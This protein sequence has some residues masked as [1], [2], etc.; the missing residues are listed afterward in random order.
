M[1]L[2]Y[3]SIL[4]LSLHTLSS[5]TDNETQ[6][7]SSPSQNNDES[8][9]EEDSFQL[10]DLNIN[11][12]VLIEPENTKP[13]VNMD[14]IENNE[15]LLESKN[16]NSLMSLMS[17]SYPL[18]SKNGFNVFDDDQQYL[19]RLRKHLPSNQKDKYR[20]LSYDEFVN[21]IKT[22]SLEARISSLSQENVILKKEISRLIHKENASPGLMEIL[23]Y[24]KEENPLVINRFSKMSMDSILEDIK[25][26]YIEPYDTIVPQGPIDEANGGFYQRYPRYDQVKVA[27]LKNTEIKKEGK[28]IVIY[29]AC[30]T[31]EM[32]K[33]SASKGD[34][35]TPVNHPLFED[36]KG[37]TFPYF[38]LGRDNKKM[39]VLN[40]GI[41][42]DYKFY[43]GKN[44]DGELAIHPNSLNGCIT[45]FDD[46]STF[47][48]IEGGEFVTPP[49]KEWSKILKQNNNQ[50]L[51][52]LGNEI[53]SMKNNIESL[54]QDNQ[55]LKW[56]FQGIKGRASFNDN[57]SKNNLILW[58]QNSNCYDVFVSCHSREDAFSAAYNHGFDHN[59]VP[60]YNTPI[61]HPIHNRNN[62]EHFPHF[63]LGRNQEKMYVNDNGVEYNYHY[64]YGQNRF[65]KRA[66]ED[67]G[68]DYPVP[69][70]A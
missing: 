24:I 43:Y 31:K 63:H 4:I 11:N 16:E 44:G 36:S 50:V 59:I 67:P 28:L 46:F 9:V 62:P 34:C 2:L 27:P 7:S 56:K 55:E 49:T 5:S 18:E 12:A 41:Y 19:K 30:D 51:L 8:K 45:S 35:D 60:Y 37:S 6:T 57:G 39:V 23:Y 26:K 3:F 20:A 40:G 68:C 17:L 14:S 58:N 21:N 15:K 69:Y 29:V 42:Y 10:N 54:T 70:Y 22:E 33:K 25:G 1:K 65:K 38:S 47:D 13:Y 32:A 53:T 52:I 61:P 66:R 64:I 48:P